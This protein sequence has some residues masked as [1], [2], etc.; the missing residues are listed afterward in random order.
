MSV[1]PPSRRPSLPSSLTTI[2]AY[3]WQGALRSFLYQMKSSPCPQRLNALENIL[4]S[5][6]QRLWQNVWYGKKK[7][8]QISATRKFISKVVAELKRQPWRGKCTSDECDSFERRAFKK[9]AHQRYSCCT[10]TAGLQLLGLLQIY[11]DFT[12]SFEAFLN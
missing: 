7:G 3:A 9:R 10:Y 1:K 12:N 4:T 2:T 11:P 6:R 5:Q 8:L